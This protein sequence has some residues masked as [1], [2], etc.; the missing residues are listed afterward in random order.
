METF[1]ARAYETYVRS[2]KVEANS[3]EDAIELIDSGLVNHYEENFSRSEIDEASVRSEVDPLA[4][5]KVILENYVKS[6]KL[7][8]EDDNALFFGY[9]SADDILATNKNLTDE[10]KL[11]LKNF[12][13]M[14]DKAQ[15]VET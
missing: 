1:Y 13:K 8:S 15:E 5:L 10:Q 7:L 4:W 9:F 11:W 12:I 14:W 6:N 2:Y 3:K